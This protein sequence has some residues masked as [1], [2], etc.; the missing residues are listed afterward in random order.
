MF[1]RRKITEGNEREAELLRAQ[2]DSLRRQIE[3]TQENQRKAQEDAA[4][5]KRIDGYLD[6]AVKFLSIAFTALS[7]FL[8]K[9]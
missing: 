8:K 6:F 4:Q 7:G 3:A 9:T 1:P 2:T 5:Q